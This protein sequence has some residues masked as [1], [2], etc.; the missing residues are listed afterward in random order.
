MTW[1]VLYHP[2]VASED[3]PKIPRNMRARLKRAIETRLLVDPI[4]AQ[5]PQG[6]A[7]RGRKMPPLAKTG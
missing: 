5:L 7:Y 3:L 4:L 2:Y 6:S 1:Q